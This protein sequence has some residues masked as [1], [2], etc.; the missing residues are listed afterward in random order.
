MLTSE[1]Q[2]KV[3]E[4]MNK[5]KGSWKGKG[6]QTHFGY[7]FHLQVLEKWNNN[8]I[9]TWRQRTHTPQSAMNY[10]AKVLKDTYFSKFR[11]VEFMV[12]I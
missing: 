3:N 8:N 11:E 1:A 5:I 4:M 7:N 12:T 6:G 2:A 9:R 10:F